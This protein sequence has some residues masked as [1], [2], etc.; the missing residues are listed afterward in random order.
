MTECFGSTRYQC[1]VYAPVFCRQKQCISYLTFL[2]VL[3][4]DVH[5]KLME[6]NH[7]HVLK[8]SEMR[9]CFKMAEFWWDYSYCMQRRKMINRILGDDEETQWDTDKQYSGYSPCLFAWYI[10]EL[11]PVKWNTSECLNKS[12]RQANLL[13]CDVQFFIYVRVNQCLVTCSLFL[14]FHSSGAT[15]Y[16]YPAKANF[17]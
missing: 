14:I 2:N 9:N 6:R 10:L 7:K 16:M 12:A 17:K 5:Y 13:R 1:T 3:G 15:L 8:S 4:W 11:K